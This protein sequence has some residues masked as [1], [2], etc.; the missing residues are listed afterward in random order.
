MRKAASQQ[1]AVKRGETIMYRVICWPGLVAVAH[2]ASGAKGEVNVLAA[3]ANPV[4]LT[5]A[6]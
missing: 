1:S 4:V 6:A 3:G 2:V 5:P